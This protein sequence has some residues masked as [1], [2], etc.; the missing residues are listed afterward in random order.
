LTQDWITGKFSNLCPGSFFGDE[1][2]AVVS[3]WGKPAP[4]YGN[5][6]EIMRERILYCDDQ[7][8]F[9]EEF[10]NRHRDS[11]EVETISDAQNVLP[12]LRKGKRLPDL[13][14]LDLYHPRRQQN[15][16]QLEEHG[17]SSLAELKLKIQEVK[18]DVE[19]AWVPAGIDV[20]REIREHYSSHQLPVLLYTQRGLALLDDRH[21]REIETLDAEWLLKDQDRI[22]PPTEAIRIRRFIRRC[23]DT[24]NLARDVKIAIVSTAAGVVLGAVLNSLLT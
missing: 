8:K 7:A 18:K 13:L 9:Q 10:F 23:K 24:R 16:A 19:A 20:L 17:N 3:Q 2:K 11:F 1:V 21:L 5:L 12:T 15:Q 22:S 4:A 14:L 6:E